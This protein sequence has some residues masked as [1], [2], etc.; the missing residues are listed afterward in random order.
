MQGCVN[1]GACRRLARRCGL[2]QTGAGQVRGDTDMRRGLRRLACALLLGALAVLPAG[3]QTVVEGRSV[4]ALRCAAYIGMAGQYGYAAG[5][6]SA[7]DRRALA[8][9]SAGV[10]A[11]WVPLEPRAAL[12]AYGAALGEIASQPQAEALID[13]H[14]EWCLRAF[15]LGTL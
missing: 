9:W 15:T 14:A 13:R 12:G 5:R 2:A 1:A 6:L 3:A 8:G 7:D 11:Q 10:L 4:Q